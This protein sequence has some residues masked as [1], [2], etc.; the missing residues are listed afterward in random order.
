MRLDTDDTTQ[1]VARLDAALRLAIILDSSGKRWHTRIKKLYL[2]PIVYPSYLISK[3]LRRDFTAKTFWGRKLILPS[4]DSIAAGICYAGLLSSGDTDLTR[5]LLRRIRRDEIFYDIGANYG[6]YT[7]LATD[8]ATAGEVHVFEPGPL[9]FSYL[10]RNFADD[11]RATLN[12]AA[13]SDSVGHIAF[14]DGSASGRSVASSVFREALEGI[15]SAYERI[16]VP[17]TT[18]DAY[19]EKNPPPTLLKIDAEGSEHTLLKASERTLRTGP[20]IVMEVLGKS[21]V[22]DESMRAVRLLEEHGYVPF[23]ILPDGS[24]TRERNLEP[25]DE[26][27]PNDYVFKRLM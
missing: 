3:R 10:E 11:R 21:F 15:G 7:A 17:A 20:E 23:R 1:A 22:K 27:E 8:I 24:L 9:C 26:A 13:V 4:W 25:T 19:L 16:D 12:N 6:F 2:R 5:Y 18:L 14:Y